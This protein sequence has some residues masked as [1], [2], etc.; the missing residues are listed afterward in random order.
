MIPSP[1]FLHPDSRV[2]DGEANSPTLS[3]RRSESRLS[4]CSADSGSNLFVQ[5]DSVEGSSSPGAL[6]YFHPFGSRDVT[7]SLKSKEKRFTWSNAFYGW[8][9]AFGSWFNVCLV[10]IPISW[11]LTLSVKTYHG[12]TFAFCIIALIPLVRL[13]DL[14]T[15]ELATRIGGSRTGLLNGSM[16]NFVEVVVAIS[17]LRKCELRVVQS[18]LIGSMLC[19]LL[20]VLGLCFFAG[21][22][23]F[24]EQGFDPTA[25]QIHSSLLSLSVGAVLLPAA[26][27][28]TL[29]NK[30][31]AEFEAQKQD[32][33]HMSH[34]VAIV[35]LFIYV[36]YLL[37]QLWS[38]TYLYN[39]QHDKKSNKLSTVI[40]EKRAHRKLHDHGN[41]MKRHESRAEAET[42]VHEP[43]PLD[44]PRRPFVSS[45]L[46]SSSSIT[47]TSRSETPSEKAAYFPPG[48]STVR[49]DHEMGGVPMSRYSAHSSNTVF[50]SSTS[51]E[52][53]RTQS[54]DAMFKEASLSAE[55]KKPQMSWFLTIFLLIV[56]TG[57]VAV[58]VDWLVEAMDGISGTI[59]KEWV[60]LILLPAIS[61]VAEIITAVKV[62]VRDELTLSVSVA[63]GSTIQTALLVIPFTVILAWIMDKPLSLLMDPFQ[64][65]VLYIAVNTMGYVV[66][67]GKSNWLEGVIL[68]CLYI[69]ITVS[70]WFYPA[71]NFEYSACDVKVI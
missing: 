52:Q 23:R 45:P 70:F 32:I 37:F 44:P 15:R 47:L 26:Y 27:H 46:S 24:S 18:T 28:F 57:A 39:D 11:A 30:I 3:V 65:M 41:H 31:D 51:A 55:K 62:S 29:G 56:V 2:S 49:L 1:E 33:L 10:L 35:L 22:L 54:N 16:S 58:T 38:H 43:L 14:S 40:K 67:D 63:V 25:T 60:G 53:I 36:A 9:V 13:H 4:D 64:S 17:A 12:L 19:K 61:S 8:R 6:P 66:A 21:G 59:K 71:P 68:I 50:S 7:S 34:G 48:A 5:G 42:I 20:L 69:I